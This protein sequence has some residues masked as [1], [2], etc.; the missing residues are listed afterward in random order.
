[1]VISELT[2]KDSWKT[3]DDGMTKKNVVQDQE[4]TVLCDIFS[5]FAVL[6]L[7]GILLSKVPIIIIVH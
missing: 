4:C 1:M 2:Q 6:R 7:P 3:S 5:S